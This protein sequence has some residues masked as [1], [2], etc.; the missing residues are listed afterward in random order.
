MTSRSRKNFIKITRWQRYKLSGH[1]AKSIVLRNA[2]KKDISAFPTFI[3][4]HDFALNVNVDVR[5]FGGN[6]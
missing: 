2:A 6:K 5:I 4:I 1:F 3:I